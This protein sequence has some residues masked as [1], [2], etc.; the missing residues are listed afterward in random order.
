MSLIATIDIEASGLS[1]NSYPIEIGIVL[2]SG[3]SYCSLIK[4]A[5]YWTDWCRDAEN[6]HG[7]SREEL[8]CH[9]KEPRVVAEQ[10]NALLA[11]STVYCDCWTLDYPWLIKLYQQAGIEKTFTLR[12]IIYTLNEELYQ[13]LPDTKGQIFA[14]LQIKRHRAT[15]D[16]RVLQLAYQALTG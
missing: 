8:V 16:A 2:P 1:C 10:L 14:S 4:P 3:D 12:D 7:I 6:V 11:I 5:R 9:G 15:N 13:Q